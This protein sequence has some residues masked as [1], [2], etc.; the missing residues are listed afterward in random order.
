MTNTE[1][2]LL[3]FDLIIIPDPVIA[4][5]M[6]ESYFEKEAKLTKRK[7][8]YDKLVKQPW[9]VIFIICKF[10]ELYNRIESL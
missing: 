10:Y 6:L 3:Q 4:K 1:S 8:Y 5:Y 7:A 9:Y 2:L